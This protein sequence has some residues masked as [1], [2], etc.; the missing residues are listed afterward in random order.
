MTQQFTDYLLSRPLVTGPIGPSDVMLVVQDGA[1]KRVPPQ[2]TAVLTDVDGS[3][4]RCQVQARYTG[5]NDAEEKTF[6]ILTTPL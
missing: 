6:E 4:E 1:L 2:L 5:L 3:G